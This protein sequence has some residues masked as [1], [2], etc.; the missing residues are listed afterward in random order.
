MIVDGPST[1]G[2]NR[3]PDRSLI[4]LILTGQRYQDRTLKA[5]GRSIQELCD[6]EGVP[7]PYFTRALRLAY[8]APDIIKLILVGPSPQT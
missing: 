3:K 6:E 8:L 5:E 2:A 1:P 7:R 4:R